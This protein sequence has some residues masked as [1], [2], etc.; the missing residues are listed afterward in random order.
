MPAQAL[1]YMTGMI[2]IEKARAG[3]EA[4]EGDAFSLRDFHDRL[5][6]LGTV[7]LPTLAREF[8]S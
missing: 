4:R 1:S 7:P 2:E 3:A 6:A 5:L 8:G